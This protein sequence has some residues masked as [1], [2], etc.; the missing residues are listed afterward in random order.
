MSNIAVELVA[1]SSVAVEGSLRN[2][3]S[4]KKMQSRRLSQQLW[5]QHQRANLRPSRHLVAYAI[6]PNALIQ[7]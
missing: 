5:M 2:S 6:V 1:V 3:G 7:S 4:I